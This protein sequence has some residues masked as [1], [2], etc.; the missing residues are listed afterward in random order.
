M[1][2]SSFV[3]FRVQ[4][5]ANDDE[6]NTEIARQWLRSFGNTPIATVPTLRDG[7]QTLDFADLRDRAKFN[8][9]LPSGDLLVE[10][11]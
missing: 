10:F 2:D 11:V 4:C 7:L 6:T 8:R 3:A 9:N 1:S 5:G